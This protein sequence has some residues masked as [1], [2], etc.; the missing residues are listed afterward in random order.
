LPENGFGARSLQRYRRRRPVPDLEIR[1]IV[2]DSIIEIHSRS[3]GTCACRRIRAALPAG[4]GMNVNLELVRSIM[5]EHTPTLGL[6]LL[7]SGKLRLLRYRWR[8]PWCSICLDAA[9]AGLVHVLTVPTMST[10][11]LGKSQNVG[12]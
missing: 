8:V 4:C 6:P 3:G 1:R 10:Q 2:I 7:P 12:E 9:P 5:T 11:T